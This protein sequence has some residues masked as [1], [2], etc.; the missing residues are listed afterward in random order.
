METLD[1]ERHREEDQV[2]TGQRL[3]LCCHRGRKSGSQWGL[4]EARK[5]SPPES[6]DMVRE[7]I[8][9]TLSCQVCSIWYDNP[10]KLIQRIITHF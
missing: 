9:V 5:E 2:K 4:E 8:P 3:E 7:H 6:A 1:I 10:G